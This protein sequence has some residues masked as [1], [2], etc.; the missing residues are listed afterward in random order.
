MPGCHMPQDQQL[1]L[2]SLRNK[3][4][5]ARVLVDNS[6]LHNMSRTLERITFVI[7]QPML[8]EK[9]F[10]HLAE[11]SL[12]RVIPCSSLSSALVQAE[13]CFPVS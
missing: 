9:L 8:T 2:R 1:L 4:L 12:Q 5:A 13:L 3:I 11:A 6:Q 10:S 7:C